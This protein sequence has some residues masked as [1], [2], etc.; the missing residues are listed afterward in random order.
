MGEQGWGGGG[1]VST[2][3]YILYINVCVL[4]T[5][6]VYIY[7]SNATAVE[8]RMSSKTIQVTGNPVSTSRHRR[9]DVCLL[10]FQVCFVYCTHI[11]TKERRD[12]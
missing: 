2:D 9:V 5:V 6:R 12:A 10:F 3:A 4:S 1:H 11:K 8:S 7:G